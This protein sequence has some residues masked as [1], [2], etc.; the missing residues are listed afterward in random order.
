MK[1]TRNIRLSFVVWSV[2]LFV[3]GTASYAADLSSWGVFVPTNQ[4][5]VGTTATDFYSD[6]QN[7]GYVCSDWDLSGIGH[8]NWECHTHGDPGHL[9]PTTNAFDVVEIWGDFY[10]C[11]GLLLGSGKMD[12]YII[13]RGT[14][15]AFDGGIGCGKYGCVDCY[16]NGLSPARECKVFHPTEPIKR[17]GYCTEYPAVPSSDKKKN[18]GK[19]DC[20]TGGPKVNKT[21]LSEDLVKSV[22]PVSVLGAI[23]SASGVNVTTGNL[24]MEEVDFSLSLPGVPLQFKRTYNSQSDYVG[25]FGK[26]WTHNYNLW[27]QELEKGKWSKKVIVWDS[28]GK[29]HQFSEIASNG[30]FI[31]FAG[32]GNKH[33]LKK[34]KLT[35]EYLFRKSDAASLLYH[36]NKR[37]RLMKITDSYGNRLDLHTEGDKLTGIS[38]QYGQISIG[39]IGNLIETVKDPKGQIYKLGYTDGMLSNVRYPDTTSLEYG[40]VNQLLADKFVDGRLKGHWEYETGKVS[41]FYSHKLGG[42]PQNWARYTYQFQKTEL[43]NVAGLTTYWY[44]NIQGVNY[45]SEILGCAICATSPHVKYDRNDWGDV[46]LETVFIDGKEV[47]T[48]YIYDDPKLPWAYEGFLRKKIENVGT[49]NERI[50][51]YT[52]I[53]RAWSE[54]TWSLANPNKKSTKEINFNSRGSVVHFKS[55]DWEKVG[56]VWQHQT[57]KSDFQYNSLGQQVKV[58]IGE[59]IRFFEYFKDTVKEG[60]NRAQLSSE[61]G[62]GGALLFS[63]YDENGNVG[64]VSDPFSGISL[65]FEYDECNQPVSVTNE[66][67]GETLDPPDTSTIPPE[68][69]VRRCYS[70]YSNMKDYCDQFWDLT[71]EACIEFCKERADYY[72]DCTPGVS[73]WVEDVCRLLCELSTGT[74]RLGCRTIF[75]TVAVFCPTY[76]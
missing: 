50:S 69:R 61:Y 24:Y 68:E 47:Q 74:L 35:G 22:E 73:Y 14:G 20:K 37:G 58:K 51:K 19:P 56:D 10:D 7:R 71:S 62:S 28:D 26:G 32:E 67:T 33:I 17:A 2:F 11:N 36:F 66:L 18:L 53:N 39:Y 54:T 23:N 49:A 13:V 42:E 30:D 41:Y 9:I 75:N 59:V 55:S 8:F 1:K 34:N 3:F 4:K 27:V 38:S 15:S 25:P 45:L 72:D 65:R 60:T 31:Q 21:G 43:T 5:I 63:D 76:Y 12:G 29:G 16:L 52:W 57:F 46:V 40:Y 70:F 44:T 64:K 6:A 48:Q